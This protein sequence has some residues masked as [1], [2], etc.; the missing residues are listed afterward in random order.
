M[1]VTT[2][3]RPGGIG[4]LTALALATLTFVSGVGLTLVLHKTAKRAVAAD[5][6][7]A[8]SPADQ[9][10]RVGDEGP[11]TSPARDWPT[12]G[13]D[14]ADR[15]RAE[16]EHKAREVL[17][18]VT[19]QLLRQARAYQWLGVDSQGQQM[20]PYLT[21]MMGGL[22]MSDPALL[23][24]MG[25]ALAERTCSHAQSDLELMMV[26]QMVL[27]APELGR[28]RT[29]DCALGGRGAEDVSLWAML[30]A[31]RGTGQPMP[32]SI[33]EIQD[34]ATDERTKQH[35]SSP[36]P[37]T[38]E[39]PG[40]PGAAPSIASPPIAT[41]NQPPSAPAELAAPQPQ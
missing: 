33:A 26:A 27:A 30:D 1:S 11:K 23:R 15:R 5:G 19:T 9:P 25:E 2:S 10:D 16:T 8:A 21:G 17:G 3:D 39:H 41:V 29:F 13:A 31:W 22:R 35:L 18:G 32:R 4:V 34:G 6:E 7:P 28:A 37:S 14:E 36:E 12:S 24:E 20:A 40:E 38:K